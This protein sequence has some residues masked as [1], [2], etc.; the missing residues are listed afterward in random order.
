MPSRWASPAGLVARDI[1][2]SH[3]CKVGFPLLVPLSIRPQGCRQVVFVGG[4][5]LTPL[6]HFRF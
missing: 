1:F 3:G 6:G 4:A 5:T 2:Y